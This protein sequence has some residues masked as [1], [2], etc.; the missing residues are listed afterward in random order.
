MYLFQD[1][2]ERHVLPVHTCDIQTR[3]AIS[4]HIATEERPGWVDP[5]GWLHIP[6]C[7]WST[8][9]ESSLPIQIL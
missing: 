9:P 6:R 1:R 8:C 4:L 7:T 3:D 2:D 5:R